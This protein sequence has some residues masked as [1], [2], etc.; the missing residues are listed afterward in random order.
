METKRKAFRSVLIFS[1]NREA[2]VASLLMHGS[3]HTDT[4]TSLSKADEDI[5]CLQED[6]ISSLYLISRNK[7]SGTEHQI[8]FD[9]KITVI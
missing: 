5:L 7:M 1:E 2:E 9:E 3:C 6:A 8:W 4:Q